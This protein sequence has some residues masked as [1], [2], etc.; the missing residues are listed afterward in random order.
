VPGKSTVAE[1]GV[2]PRL[3]MSSV[4]IPARVMALVI[5][6]A[7]VA[8]LSREAASN[9][10]DDVFTKFTRLTAAFLDSS[11][12][13]EIHRAQSPLWN[14]LR[15]RGSRFITQFGNR[16]STSRGF[17]A[18]GTPWASLLTFSRKALAICNLGIS[19]GLAV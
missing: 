13:D 18:A 7:I 19:R 9:T 17:T 10:G 4:E 14:R 6:A 12:A 8:A 11:R 15:G 2:A 5:C 3:V 1:T 16:S